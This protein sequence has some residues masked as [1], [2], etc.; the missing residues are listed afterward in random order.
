MGPGQTGQGNGVRHF[1]DHRHKQTHE[2]VYE[3]ISARRRRT[4]ASQT[5]DFDGV[6]PITRFV[7][8]GGTIGFIGFM[9]HQLRKREKDK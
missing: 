6:G 1:D 2:H 5:P 8:V 7:L 3:H 4:R 9:A